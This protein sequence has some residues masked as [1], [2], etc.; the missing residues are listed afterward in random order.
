VRLEARDRARLASL[1][2]HVDGLADTDGNRQVLQVLIQGDHEARVHGGHQEVK[3]PVVFVQ[4]DCTSG[5]DRVQALS[6]YHSHALASMNAV[7][8]AKRPAIAVRLMMLRSEKKGLIVMVPLPM[9][10]SP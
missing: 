3:H 10:T 8:V 9:W 2:N 1:T 6:E 5:S 7:S 4:D